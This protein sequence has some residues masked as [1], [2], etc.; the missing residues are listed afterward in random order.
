ME[1]AELRRTLEAE[2]A[3]LR[4]QLSDLGVRENSTTLSG[5]LDLGDSFSDQGH[6]TAER[7]EVLGLAD[8]LFKTMADVD[9]ALERIDAG[10][11]G[12]CERC[13]EE[14]GDARL[15]ARPWSRYCVACK[16]MVHT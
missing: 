5:D 14:I 15:E 7:A 2:R 16:A 4:K 10:T 3:S 6:A 13:G 9:A 11:Y 1:T 12:T 8:G